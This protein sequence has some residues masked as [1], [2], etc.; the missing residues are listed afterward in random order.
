MATY[1]KKIKGKNYDKKLIDAADSSV[2]GKGD[3][4]ISLNDAK[5]I[6]RLVKDSSDYTDLE[7]NTMKYI[8]DHYDFTPEA[9]QWFRA[10]VRKW[11][12]SRGTAD[13]KP[14]RPAQ[15]P[16]KTI[17]AAQREEEQES[18]AAPRTQE[19]TGGMEPASK[20]GLFRKII[21][22]ILIILVILVLALLLIPSSR[23]YIQSCISRVLE[24]AE[25]HKV[26]ETKPAARPEQE[27]PEQKTQAVEQPKEMPADQPPAP[28]KQEQ[29]GDYYTV[30]VKDDLISISE[31][32]LGSYTRWV[33][34]FNANR[35][36]IKN[37]TLIFPGQKLKIPQI[38]K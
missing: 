5:K 21:Q 31:K 18:Y 29:S 26:Q 37:P 25:Q 34:L 3:G 24:S 32:V 22:F 6:L 7:K 4:R 9:D 16:R 15:R 12:A 27:A 17:P 35:D 14:A 2:K 20:P 36:V 38:K 33:D 28:E 13:K 8:R 1:Y 23:K 19:K 10:E 11:A 30:Q